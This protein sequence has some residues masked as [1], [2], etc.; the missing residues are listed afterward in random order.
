MD[1]FKEL[2]AMIGR[3]TVA[4]VDA[5]LRRPRS[6]SEALLLSEDQIA[7]KRVVG[8]LKVVGAGLAAALL[9]YAQ[10]KSEPEL[11][12]RVGTRREGGRGVGVTVGGKRRS[13]WWKRDAA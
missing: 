4:V 13:W 8:G 2:F 6:F 11:T 10:T 3:G 12:V 7:G 9:A 5:E 1:Q